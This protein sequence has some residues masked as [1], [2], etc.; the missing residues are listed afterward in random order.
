MTAPPAARRSQES[1]ET[2]G[3]DPMAKPPTGTAE[4]QARDYLWMVRA[5]NNG[6]DAGPTPWMNASRTADVGGT[7]AV[8][9]WGVLPFRRPLSFVVWTITN[10]M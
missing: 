1:Y 3:A 8:A 2:N 9:T 5:R 10:E 6:M 4:Q 7:T